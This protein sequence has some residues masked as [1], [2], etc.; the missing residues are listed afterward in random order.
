MRRAGSLSAESGKIP[1]NVQL[2]LSNA[3][4]ELREIEW[5]VLQAPRRPQRDKRQPPAVHSRIAMAGSGSAIARSLRLSFGERPNA[6][7]TCFPASRLPGFLAFWQLSRAIRQGNLQVTYWI[8]R[9]S[10]L[11]TEEI[12]NS[13]IDRRLSH[14]AFI[15]R[16][17]RESR[18]FSSSFCKW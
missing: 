9:L 4:I 8:L 17:Q 18:S 1:K 11:V 10:R 12:S 3:T 15:G 16:E 14:A 5:Q 7:A 13:G 6:I 2:F